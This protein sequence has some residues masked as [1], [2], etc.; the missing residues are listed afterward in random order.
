MKDVASSLHRPHA[1]QTEGVHCSSFMRRARARTSAAR[2]LSRRFA[3]I[4]VHTG[5]DGH[6]N[7]GLYC[8]SEHAFYLV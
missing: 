7:N 1:A 3:S 8:T 4:S 6:L 5:R 2:L